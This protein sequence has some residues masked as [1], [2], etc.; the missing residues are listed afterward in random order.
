MRDR[1]RV[2][3]FFFGGLGLVAAGGR[4]DVSTVLPLHT[5]THPHPQS[6]PTKPKPF[7]RKRATLS[8][9]SR[10][11]PGAMPSLDAMKE[12]ALVRGLVWGISHVHPL[13]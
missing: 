12:T 6:G 11:K 2:D 4:F 13:G 10:L 3:V 8:A 7:Q 1:S 5:H 9:P